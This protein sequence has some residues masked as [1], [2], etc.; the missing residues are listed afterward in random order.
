MNFVRCY[1]MLFNTFDCWGRGF[2]FFF[3]LVLVAVVLI[4]VIIITLE[5]T[6]VWMP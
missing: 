6:G 1:T 2:C 5:L 4:E 3:K